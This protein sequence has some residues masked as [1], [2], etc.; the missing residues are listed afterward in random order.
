MGEL[1]TKQNDIS[2]NLASWED[3]ANVHANGGYGD[4]DE[5]VNDSSAITGTV[6]RD[7]D[8]L[9]PFLP[10]QSLTGQRLLHLQCHIGNDTISWWRLGAQAVHGLDFSPRSLQHARRLTKQAGAAVTYVEGDARF[11]SAALPEKL[12]QFDVVVTSAG[13]ITWLPDLKDWAE[14]IADLLAP[15]GIFMI[16]DNHPLL[17]ALDNEGLTI[18][19][20]YFSGTESSYDADTSYTVVTDSSE[21]QT[22]THQRNHNWAHDFQEIIAALREAGLV[23]ESLGEHQETDWQSLPMLTFDHDKEGWVLP[24]GYPQ[25]PLTFSLVARKN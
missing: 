11:A 21:K 4:L 13:T 9:Q 7:L 1:M 16:R 17:F 24:A 3:R 20:D 23:I 25:I 15:N 10:Q 2:D 5:F 22:L 8:V 19:N 6:K 12:G 18:K 14:S